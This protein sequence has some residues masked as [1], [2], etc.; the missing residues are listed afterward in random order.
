MS[1]RICDSCGEAKDLSG[2][3]TCSTGHFICEDCVDDLK[4]PDRDLMETINDVV[5]TFTG[6]DENLKCP[7]CDESL[8]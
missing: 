4:H 3:M 5:K 6:P 2:S 8:R 7:L 1:E